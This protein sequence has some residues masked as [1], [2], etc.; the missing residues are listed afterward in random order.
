[1][2]RT[3]TGALLA[4]LAVL[5]SV[6]PGGETHAEPARD[7]ALQAAFIRGGELWMKRDGA[8]ERQLTNGAN[9]RAPKW[10]ADGRFVAYAGGDNGTDLW[11]YSLESGRAF[12][13]A[14]GA[15]QYEWSPDRNRLAF[16]IDAVLN[17][18]DIERGGAKP[19]RNVTGGVGSY[20][21]L[22]D[23]NG[24]L[25]SSPAELLPSGWSRVR[26]FVV[27]ADA[28]M[29]PAKAK[30]FFTLPA[31]SD[32]FFAVTTS[33]FKWSP[34]RKW[35]SFLAIPTASLSADSDTLCVLSADGK[36]FRTVAVMIRRNEWQRWA[37]SRNLLGYIEGEGRFA[38]QNKQLQVKEFPVIRR[39]PYTP[40]GYA[41]RDFV[42]EN[43][44]FIVVSRSKEAEWS[45]DP[46]A[47]P[48]PALVRVDVHNN[49]RKQL[50]Y[51]PEGSGDFDPA[52][53]ERGKKLAWVRTDRTRAAVW[54]A[55]ADGADARP[56]I[57]AVDMADS[58]YEAY[59]WGDVIAWYEPRA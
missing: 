41:D 56:Y 14:G 38:I 58:Y 18:A 13:V 15:A 57:S 51:P 55:G 34:D 12:S 6:L 40:K 46:A 25:V 54:L 2:I 9:A 5:L 17:V 27:P 7:R 29:D 45:N 22:P 47:R 21:W 28:G 20:S 8:D 3:M 42:W 49:D 44:R 26:L 31:Q 19:F 16:V 35:I 1:M 10:S 36:T 39:V 59:D 11:V 50:T 43:D 37:P 4:L 23:G 30:P 53:L 52:S 48:L 33:S 32:S 24:F